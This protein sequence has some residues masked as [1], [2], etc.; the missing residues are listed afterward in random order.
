FRHEGHRV[1]RATRIQG[2]QD[3]GRRSDLDQVAPFEPFS[4]HVPLDSGSLLSVMVTDA[5]MLPKRTCSSNGLFGPSSAGLGGPSI[6]GRAPAPFPTGRN[7][8]DVTRSAPKHGAQSIGAP[9][10][11]RTAQQGTGRR[12]AE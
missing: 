6:D 1:V 5:D 4:A 9:P 8:T 7:P 10:M 11:A 12:V 3:L 2:R